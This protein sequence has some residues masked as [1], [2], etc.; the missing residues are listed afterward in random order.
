MGRA[1]LKS[2]VHILAPL[3]PPDR[4]V[5]FSPGRPPVV[6]FDFRLVFPSCV[7]VISF[8]RAEENA[9]KLSGCTFVNFTFAPPPETLVVGVTR[10]VQSSVTAGYFILFFVGIFVD[11][12]AISRD[13]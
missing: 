11:S 1:R 9:A 2:N 4:V 5:F 10:N 7:T 13:F 6:N 3:P 12:D 8:F